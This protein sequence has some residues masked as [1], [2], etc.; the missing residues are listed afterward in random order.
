MVY[1]VSVHSIA[2]VNSVTLRESCVPG[3]RPHHIVAVALRLQYKEGSTSKRAYTQKTIGQRA[4]ARV[5]L[6]P[7]LLVRCRELFKAAGVRLQWTYEG[8]GRIW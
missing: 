1:P 3:L 7:R 5:C 4:L 6:H 8:V 2:A